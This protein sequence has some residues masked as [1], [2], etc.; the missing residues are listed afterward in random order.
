MTSRTAAGYA[1]R[2]EQCEAC[3]A[4][5]RQS[6]RNVRAAPAVHARCHASRRHRK[7][8]SRIV[9]YCQGHK[10]KGAACVLPAG[11]GRFLL[12]LRAARAQGLAAHWQAAKP[13]YA[14]TEINISLFLVVLCS[15]LPAINSAGRER[16]QQQQ[17][18]MMMP[19]ADGR[20]ASTSAYVRLSN[21][22]NHQ[23]TKVA[24]YGCL[25][26]QGHATR[27]SLQ[28]LSRHCGH[29]AKTV[30]LTRARTDTLI[31]V[32]TQRHRLRTRHENGERE[33]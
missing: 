2:S 12:L 31:H 3:R 10:P 17:R 25:S 28:D 5:V 14:P 27:V 9:A 22:Y 15:F 30:S 20:L 32:R 8:R 21:K 24:V 26:G 33:S 29:V 18:Q 13:E 1:E 11:S 6:S 7:S 19:I 16:R 4:R 23:R